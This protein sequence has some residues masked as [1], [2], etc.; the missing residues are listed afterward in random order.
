M[1]TFERKLLIDL[2]GEGN[3]NNP[4]H[5]VTIKQDIYIFFM[6]RKMISRFISTGN[7]NDKLLINN[8]IICLNNFGIKK[9]NLAFRTICSDVEFGVVKSCL[10]FLN[11]F[12][13]K[14]DTTKQNHIMR[15]ILEDVSQRYHLSIN[16]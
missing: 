2:L 15:G 13:L 4:L 8:I 9:V 6:V 5:K 14:N 12:N 10:L 1:I 7:V 11:S 3:E 16:I